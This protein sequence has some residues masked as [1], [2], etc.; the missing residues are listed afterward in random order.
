MHADPQPMTHEQR[1]RIAQTVAD[2]LIVRYGESVKAI[3]L[4]G[5]LARAEDGPYSD[6]EMFC[7]LRHPGESR[8]YEWCAGGWK[9]EVNVLTEAALREEAA[10]LDGDWALT[11]GAYVRI[12]PLL[13]SGGCFADLKELVLGHSP[14]EMRAM[15]E[16]WLAS[17]VYERIGKLRNAAFQNHHQVFPTLAVEL[18]TTGDLRDPSMVLAACNSLWSGLVRW[19]DQRGYALVASPEISF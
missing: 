14:E 10:E 8:D 19:A 3:G 1:L 4:Y 6:I 17:E 16:Q 7:V 11:H 13:D 12:L 9:A 2:R 5:S 15:V 18:V